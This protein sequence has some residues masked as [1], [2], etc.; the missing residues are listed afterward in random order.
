MLLRVP[1][2]KIIWLQMLLRVP[3]NKIIWLQMKPVV[4]FESQKVLQHHHHFCLII[5][6]NDVAVEESMG[7]AMI[8]SSL[9]D[10]EQ[11]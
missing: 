11:L 2:N 7:A 4:I 3:P 10:L 1:P 6:Q 5:C 8:H 9:L